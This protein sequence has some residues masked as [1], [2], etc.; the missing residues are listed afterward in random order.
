M[1]S[2]FTQMRE[3]VLKV[4]KFHINFGHFR[5]TGLIKSFPG[6]VGRRKARKSLPEEAWTVEDGA[7]TSTG[8][9]R[10]SV[11]FFRGVKQRLLNDGGKKKSTKRAYRTAYLS[12]TKF[13]LSLDNM[14][15]LLDDQLAVYVAYRV[16]LGDF[17]NTI[18]SYLSGIKYMLG[19][20]GIEINTRTARLRSLIKACKYKNDRV[21]HRQ[22]ISESLLVKLIKQ[23]DEIFST[24][25]YLKQ[26]YRCM[27]VM[28]FYGMLRVGEMAS[29]DHPVLARDIH[30]NHKL[31][32]VQIILRTSKTHGRGDQPQYVKFNSHD[33]RVFLYNRKFCPYQ[34]VVDF[35]NMRGPKLND[36]DPFFVFT[37]N[38]PVRPYQMQAVLKRALSRFNLDPSDYGIHSLRIGYATTLDHRHV[39]L[40]VIR[41]KGRWKGT[42]VVFRYIRM[43]K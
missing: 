21:I 24:Q 5:M 23:L 28:G 12:F 32:K 20:D 6:Y 13:M 10:L 31:K 38:T 3:L 2:C 43:I 36:D 40:D 39:S 26:L 14:P 29:G 11:E 15:Q 9:T 27:L 35:M 41:R 37:D 17:S 25:P 1:N 22:P 7:S 34:V 19:Q 8:A 4:M 42:N 33:S 30:F 18:E 16:E